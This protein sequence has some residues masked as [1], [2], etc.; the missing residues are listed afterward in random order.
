MASTVGDLAMARHRP[1]PEVTD[2][3]TWACRRCSRHL[4]TVA[5]GVL[6]EP[7]GDRS[8]LPCI[9]H[10]PRCKARNIRLR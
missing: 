6:T 8:H 9:R 7:N 4:G 3:A 2:A 10:C 5:D 1:R